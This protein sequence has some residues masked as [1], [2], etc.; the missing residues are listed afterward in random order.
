MVRIFAVALLALLPMVVLAQ[1]NTS[2]PTTNKMEVAVWDTYVKKKDG[3]VMHFD[4]LA[5]SHQRDTSSDT[6][7]P[8]LKA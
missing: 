6:V 4:I 8:V 1:R 5:P 7:M 3:T 2:T